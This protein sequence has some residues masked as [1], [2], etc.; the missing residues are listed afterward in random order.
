MACLPSG[1]NNMLFQKLESAGY[2]DKSHCDPKLWP[3]AAV[4]ISSNDSAL[5]IFYAQEIFF[6]Q[7]PF[8]AKESSSE[9][10][11]LMFENPPPMWRLPLQTVFVLTEPDKFCQFDVYAEVGPRRKG[12][13][14][15][16]EQ[17]CDNVEPMI[18]VKTSRQWVLTFPSLRGFDSS[19]SIARSSG[20]NLR[21]STW[22][23]GVNPLLGLFDPRPNMRLIE[24]PAHSR[25]KLSRSRELT[26]GW[27]N[28]ELIN[29]RA[30][31][32]ACVASQCNRAFCLY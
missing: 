24:V 4:V 17:I 13:L 19:A 31:A 2:I 12:P 8:R 7:S 26:F 6:N 28:Y 22:E 21:T 32:A 20:L 9:M 25:P 10:S 18:L 1:F 3:G 14:K 29:Q 11:V 30:F 5:D 23:V 27:K 16:G 15:N